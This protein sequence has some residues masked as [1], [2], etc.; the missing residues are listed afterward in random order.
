MKLDQFFKSVFQRKQNSP[1]L[2][3]SGFSSALIIDTNFVF[4]TKPISEL[5]W[6]EVDPIGPIILLALPQL[7]SEVDSKKRDG[8]LAKKARQ[9]NRYFDS[10]DDVNLPIELCKSAPKVYLIAPPIRGIDWSGISDLDPKHPDDILAAQALNVAATG[11]VEPTFFGFDN[12]PC[13]SVR[14]HGGKALRP[15]NHWLLDSEPHPKDKLVQ[16]LKARVAELESDKPKFEIQIHLDIPNGIEIPQAQALSDEDRKKFQKYI[17]NELKPP[18]TEYGP[19]SYL[20]SENDKIHRDFIE[21][22]PRFLDAFPNFLSMFFSQFLCTVCIKNIGKVTAD[23]FILEIFANEC[24]VREQFLFGYPNGPSPQ[25]KTGFDMPAL[26][27]PNFSI[28]PH[29]FVLSEDLTTERYMNYRCQDFRHDTQYEIQLFMLL[30]ASFGTPAKITVRATS[31]NGIGE[32][33]ENIPVDFSIV[34]PPAR[35]LFD[36]G[37]RKFLREFPLQEFLGKRIS[38]HDFSILTYPDF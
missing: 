21:S 12:R 9:F 20:N 30:R 27:R 1:N 26:Q 33:T 15:P 8:R 23:K 14:R 17:L 34:H 31:A 5:P 18:R 32:T 24:E 37:N 38:E 35:E 11:D 10:S 29:E 3:L 2:D 7:L 25:Y 6:K 13:N 22:V 4:H 19:Q 16:Q 28:A 36:F